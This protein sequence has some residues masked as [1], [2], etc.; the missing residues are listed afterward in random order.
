MAVGL[1]LLYVVHVACYWP[2]Q[3]LAEVFL[4][5]LMGRDDC[6]RSLRILLREVVRNVKHD[7]NFH[8]FAISIMHDHSDTKLCELDPILKARGF[9]FL[10]VLLCYF[11]V[12][13]RS[14]DTVQLT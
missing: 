3:L 6:L 14:Y 12:K 9:I 8:T 7:M 13:P 5:M 10:T 1:S 2:V 11:V 4:D